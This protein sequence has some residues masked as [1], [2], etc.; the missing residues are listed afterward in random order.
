MTE[1]RLKRWR[2]VLGGGQADGTG[3]SLSAA[4]SRLDGA[5]GMLYNRNESMSPEDK[6]KNRNNVGKG[7]SRPNVSRWL[8]DIREF[9]PSECS[10][11]HAA[12]C[13]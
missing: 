13:L 12:R 4:E 2:L 11:G 3:C 1:D 9:F 7:A 8:G 6:E 10:Q 5:L